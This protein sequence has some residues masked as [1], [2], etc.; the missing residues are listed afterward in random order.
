MKEVRFGHLQRNMEKMM[1]KLALLLV[2]ALES[3]VL[4]AQEAAPD[5]L[6]QAVTLEVIVAMQRERDQNVGDA[7]QVANVVETKV[8]PLFD[9]AR[10]TQI[11]MARNWRVATAEQ[12]TA[13]VAEFKTLLVRTYSAA[14]AAFRDQT[15]EFR[16][17][18]MSSGDTEVTVKSVVKQ[19][20]TAP[21]S[22]DYDMEK[23]QAG[24]K[25]YDIKVAGVSLITTYRDTFSEKIRDDGVDGLIKLL[26]DKNRQ[27]PRKATPS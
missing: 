11:A 17:L 27:A 3:P 8:L 9:F 7:A 25:V 20:G 18:A 13:L 5:A 21:V 23:I 22:I 2:L 16:H 6:L 10:M 4:V 14:L 19:S 24:W 12:Q 26:T 1:L 15:I